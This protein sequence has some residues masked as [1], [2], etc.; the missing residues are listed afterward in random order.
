[1]FGKLDNMSVSAY[2]T[3]DSIGRVNIGGVF[4]ITHSFFG[5]GFK[6]TEDDRLYYQTK[7]Y[8][9]NHGE[10]ISQIHITKIGIVESKKFE[11]IFMLIKTEAF[12]TSEF[13]KNYG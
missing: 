13:K 9:N 8:L 3:T 1:M 6:F 11:E 4:D 10:T 7:I 2:G 12:N 5:L